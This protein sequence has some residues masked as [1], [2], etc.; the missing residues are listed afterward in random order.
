M[1]SADAVVTVLVGSNDL[2]AGKTGFIVNPAAFADVAALATQPEGS[3]P[4]AL[5]EYVP[6]A[7]AD[8]ENRRAI[9]KVIL[10]P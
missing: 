1:V 9:G 5:T 3:G 10:V 2:F 8:L 7:H 4:F 6:N